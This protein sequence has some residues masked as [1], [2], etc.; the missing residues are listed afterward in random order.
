MGGTTNREIPFD[1]QAE[2]HQ[3]EW[4][5]NQK[6]LEGVGK[7]WQNGVQ[8]E[9][10]LPARQWLLGIWPPIRNTLD[11]YIRASGIQPNAGKHNLK[12]SWTQCANLFFPFRSYPRM[13]AVLAGFLTQQLGVKVTRIESLELEYAA[14]GNLEPE[15]L[16]GELGGKRGSGQTSPDVAIIFGCED[17]RSGI[18]LIENKYTEHSFYDCSGAKKPL[19]KIHSE[20]GLTP[21]PDPNRCHNAIRVLRNP[22]E[23]CQEQTWGRKYWSV[24]KDT[25]NKGVIQQRGCCPALAG[26]YQLFRQQALAQGIANS[27]LFDC[28]ISGVAYDARNTALIT[29]FRS[30]GLGNFASGWRRLFNTAVRFHCFTH[31]DFVSYIRQSSDKLC[32][33]WARYIIARYD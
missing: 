1:K 6:E 12:S 33:M 7:G 2:S 19:S 30:I 22:E 8:R 13:A 32:Q 17:G 25:V 20:Q 15:R 11:E 5:N 21:N 23:M 18:Y 14:P 29:C 4:R 10:I 9:H 28:V 26:G 16:L 27:G 24:L 31:Q 3:V